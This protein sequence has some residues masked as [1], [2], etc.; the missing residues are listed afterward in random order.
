MTKRILY[1]LT[2]ALII[3]FFV[4]ANEESR[5]R[6]AFD[7]LTAQDLARGTEVLAS[8][9][10]EGRGLASNGEEKTVSV[11]QL[12]GRDGLQGEARR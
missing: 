3:G 8:D 6:A 2:F 4:C 10:F 5:I 1:V 11:S 7:S 12:E 9:E